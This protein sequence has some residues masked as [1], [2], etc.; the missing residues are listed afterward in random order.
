MTR[1]TLI[2]L[3]VLLLT[4]SIPSNAEKD[5]AAFGPSIGSFANFEIK[6]FRYMEPY[7]I[8]VKYTFFGAGT[9]RLTCGWESKTSV[10]SEDGTYFS[11]FPILEEYVYGRGGDTITL[12][13]YVP[14]KYVMHENLM[15]FTD[16]DVL[17]DS[18]SYNTVRPS[19]EILFEER[20]LGSNRSLSGN[21]FIDVS[22]TG[23][24]MSR[25][26]SVD[27]I[28]YNEHLLSDSRDIVPLDRIKLDFYD[29]YGHKP[30]APRINN[31]SLIVSGDN[32]MDFDPLIGHGAFL[33]DDYIE[34]PLKWKKDGEGLYHPILH[35]S[36]FGY[37][38]GKGSNPYTEKLE[39]P[40][41][42]EQFPIYHIKIKDTQD[43]LGTYFYEFDLE[44]TDS[45]FGSCRNSTWCVEVN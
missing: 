37:D 35:E 6:P 27:I 14:G 15:T 1:V 7:S 5:E 16:Y 33:F 22:D 40:K 2:P 3:A 43:N 44:K 41:S 36:V 8:K 29:A 13:Y 18:F 34:I 38:V 45:Y 17:D 25:Q 32:Y 10:F 24:F 4:S 39:L 28:N 30:F 12:D 11:Y 19:E 21:T 26:E 31:L 20:N 9:H 23:Q 42:K